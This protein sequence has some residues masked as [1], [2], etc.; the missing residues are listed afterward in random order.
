MGD[1][2]TKEIPTVPPDQEPDGSRKNKSVGVDRTGIETHEGPPPSQD[3][4]EAP[5]GGMLPQDDPS[6]E[7]GMP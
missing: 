4:P 2:S 7:Q 1:E 5:G 3:N 6:R